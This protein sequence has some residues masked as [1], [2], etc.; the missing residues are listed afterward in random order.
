MKKSIKINLGGLVL[1]VDD[2][3]YDL[4]RNY[5]DQLQLR[6]SQVPGES[7]ILNDIETRMAELFQE[8]LVPGKEVI[9]LADAKEVI[10]VMGEPEVIGEAGAEEAPPTLPPPYPGRGRRM[11]RDPS[12]QRIAGVCSGLAAYFK[13]DPLF[14]RILFVV[15][16]LAYGA[17]ILI[18]FV[19]WI[20]V[21]EARTAA[22]KLEMYGEPVNVYNIER[23][24]R[25]EYPYDPADPD[26][27]PQARRGSQGTVIGR[28]VHAL[29]RVA[30]V[31]IKIIG[32]IIAFSFIIA[33]I[34]ILG[35]MI[36]LA[37][38]GKAWFI[39]SDW[40]LNGI[41]LNE[42]VGF[43]VS[44]T[45]ATIGVIGLIL[46]VAI[47]LIG[48]IYG[49]VK[50]IFRFKTRDRVG[51]LSLSG[52]WLIT[53]IVVI[54]LAI[55]EG[56][57]YSQQSRTTEDKVLVLPQG[58]R[59]VMKSL[60]YPA[61]IN[62]NMDEYN[63]HN[64]FWISRENDSV[65][66]LIRPTVR[67]E[68]TQDSTA[69]IRIRKT[70]RGANIRDAREYAEQINYTCSL[71]DSVLVVDPVYRLSERNR[72]HAQEVEVTVNLPAGALIYLDKSLKY[73]LYGVENSEDT[74][75]GDLVGEEWIMTPDGLTRVLKKESVQK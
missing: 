16:T 26:F 74:W 43:F 40:N 11:Y 46:L 25:Q 70:A 58:K 68:Y 56:V 45:A 35:S 69:G 38:S 22:E 9:N 52:L 19:L 63:F 60:P 44:P 13:V 29:A 53:L 5:L 42:A 34:A 49:V 2:D 28:M 8:K 18:Y 50:I 15:F 3:A 12:N 36:G 39:N 66:L 4:L 62:D 65:T 59:L 20:G 61:D 17:G 30:L 47:P 51:A 6:F 21:P 33:G 1:H 75:S 7:E 72:F 37:V 27:Q 32:F 24:V 31:F 23:Q 57:Q 55:N 67:I 54:V 14:V 64:E 48:L 71:Q 10:E 41:G 73:L